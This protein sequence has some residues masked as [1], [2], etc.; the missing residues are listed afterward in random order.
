MKKIYLL[1]GDNATNFYQEY[2]VDTCIKQGFNNVS[3]IS[4]DEKTPIETVIQ[5]V[6]NKVA[7]SLDSC[8]ITEKDYN[9]IIKAF[10]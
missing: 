3:V 9:K 6:L 10:K 5:K 1:H 7:G 4:I 2:G 8:I